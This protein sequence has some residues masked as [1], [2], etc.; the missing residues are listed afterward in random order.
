MDLTTKKIPVLV[1]LTSVL[2]L[3]FSLFVKSYDFSSSTLIGGLNKR[4]LDIPL[5]L[6]EVD[7][8]LFSLNFATVLLLILISTGVGIYTLI[9][10]EDEEIKQWVKKLS[11]KKLFSLKKR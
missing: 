2:F 11:P 5:N 10:K 1:L 6:Y 8:F 7:F 3:V 4:G 9:Y